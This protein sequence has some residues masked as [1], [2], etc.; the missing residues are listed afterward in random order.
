M[1]ENQHMPRPQRDGA[2]IAYFTEHDLPPCRV[3]HR[4]DRTVELT[5][6]VDDCDDRYV[7]VTSSVHGDDH[8]LVCRN[9]RVVEACVLGTLEEIFSWVSSHL[10]AMFESILSREHG[11]LARG[12]SA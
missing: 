9:S 4:H 1:K 3:V 7:R 12:E 11:A 5:W 8:V 10:T 2:T 6:V